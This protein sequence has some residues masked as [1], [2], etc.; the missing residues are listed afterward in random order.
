MRMTKPRKAILDSL[1]HFRKPVTAREIYSYL[2]NKGIKVD[3]ASIYRNLSFLPK[4]KPVQEYEF[5]DGKKRYEMVK[6]D[7]H[8]HLVCQKCGDVEDIEMKEKE[9]LDKVETKSNFKIERHSLEFF[10]LC[11]NCQ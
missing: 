9:L 8:H 2:K 3:L 6:R 10:G 1:F 5:G 7:H 11:Q 4:I